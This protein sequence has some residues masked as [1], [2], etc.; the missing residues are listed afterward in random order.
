MKRPKSWRIAG[1]SRLVAAVC[2]RGATD[3]PFDAK[4]VLDRYCAGNPSDATTRFERKDHAPGPARRHQRNGRPGA[5]V[6]R[7]HPGRAADRLS[8]DHG[9]P[10]SKYNEHDVPL[11]YLVRHWTQRPPCGASAV[12]RTPPLA[13]TA[14]RTA[15]PVSS[16][17]TSRPALAHCRICGYVRR[18]PLRHWRLAPGQP[19]LNA[20]SSRRARSPDRAA[21]DA[22]GPLALRRS[23]VRSPGSRR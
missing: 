7:R 22:A 4:A 18:I 1:R 11:D 12:G 14:P 23:P 16:R 20:R 19:R 9:A 10:E 5:A 15:A 13:S 21:V 17:S 3:G 2:R 6:P 8:R